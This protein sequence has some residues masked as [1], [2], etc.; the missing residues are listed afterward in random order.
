MATPRDPSL[1]FWTRWLLAVGWLLVG[2]GVLLAIA[3]QTDLFLNGLAAPF[4]VPFWDTPPGPEVSGYQGWVYGMLGATVA[5]WG[6]FAL[7]VTRHGFARGEAW[8]R[9]YLAAGVALWFV[10]DTTVSALHAVWANVAFNTLVLVAVLLPV[11]AARRAFGASDLE[12]TA[13]REAADG[14]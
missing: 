13:A 6:V 12:G 4:H 10:V 11:V 3:G 7:A 2:A 8:A 14:P 9:R 1:R 5:G